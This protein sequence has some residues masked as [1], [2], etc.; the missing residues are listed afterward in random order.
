[1]RPHPA[2]DPASRAT[3]QQLIARTREREARILAWR[4]EGRKLDDIAEQLGMTW[5]G[6]GRAYK[7]ALRALVPQPLFEEERRLALARLDSLRVTLNSRLAE[8]RELEITPAGG[9]PGRLNR[10]GP[11]QGAARQ[12][13]SPKTLDPSCQTHARVTERQMRSL[14]CHSHACLVREEPGNGTANPPYL[15]DGLAL[16]LLSGNLG[17]RRTCKK[18]GL[19]SFAH[20]ARLGIPN[21]RRLP[22][23]IQ[24]LS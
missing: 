24:P 22:C 17:V 11:R 21:T 15:I 19:E 2:L 16:H 18:S 23:R 7:R 13:R 4:K 14:L 3:R 6:V 8:L 20:C 12:S 9:S 5:S 10:P 1:M